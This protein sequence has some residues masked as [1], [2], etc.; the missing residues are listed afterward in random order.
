MDEV[1]G[2]EACEFARDLRLRLWSEHLALETSDTSIFGPLEGFET[3]RSRA[4]LPLVPAVDHTRATPR[5]TIALNFLWYLINRLAW[6]LVD[7]SGL[8]PKGADAAN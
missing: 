4:V 1:I 5:P 8:G 2:G 3:W 7:P 6:D